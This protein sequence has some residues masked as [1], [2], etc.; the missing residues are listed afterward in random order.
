MSIDNFERKNNLDREIDEASESELADRSHDS[1]YEDPRKSFENIL[2]HIETNYIDFANVIDELKQNNPEKVELAENIIGI[3]FDLVIEAIDRKQ[4][5]LVERINEKVSKRESKLIF[6][7]SFVDVISNSVLAGIAAA[8]KVMRE[9]SQ[10]EIKSKKDLTETRKRQLILFRRAMHLGSYYF[11]EICDDDSKLDWELSTKEG[12]VG[13]FSVY[14]KGEGNG[15]EGKIFPTGSS[16][17]FYFKLFSDIEERKKDINQIRQALSS[18]NIS[19]KLLDKEKL[20]SD[21]ESGK[22]W[23]KY[24]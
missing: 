3:D 14:F 24:S 11:Q 1:A 13:K 20:L 19:D 21:V 18:R 8:K 12:Y 7:N 17:V 15:L 22:F 6:A 10:E 5:E 23:E 2:H 9:I 4:I 16:K